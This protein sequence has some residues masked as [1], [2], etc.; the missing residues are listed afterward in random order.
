MKLTEDAKNYILCINGGSSSLKFGIYEV[1][2][3]ALVA[4][5]QIGPIG[6]N[7][8]YLEIKGASGQIIAHKPAGQKNIAAAVD[9]LI[10]WLKENEGSY[11]IRAIG[12]RVV[13][14]GPVH[15][16]PELITLQLLNNLQQYVYLAPNHLPDEISTIKKF[17]NAYPELNQVAC[18]DTAFH[19]QIPSY[20]K[21]Y[22]LPAEYLEKGL[23]KYGFHG[24]SYA[25]IMQQLK[26]QDA[27]AAQQ[28]IIIAHLGNGASMAAVDHGVSID[29]TMG[30]SPVGGLIMGSRCGDLDPGVLL[31][32]MNQ[33]QMAPAELDELL[34]KKAGL[35][36]IAGISD[37]Q[38]LL[39]IASHQPEAEAAL[40]AFCYSTR[41]FIGALAAAL[42]GLDTLVFTGG[43]GENAAPL[44]QRICDGLNFMGIE[45]DTQKNIGN[46]NIIS[47]TT[48]RVTIRV[49]KTDEELMMAQ[50]VNTTIYQHKQ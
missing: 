28:K 45:L 14:G 49:I 40:Q 39:K 4:R 33:Y 42:Q 43:I 30:I 1:H 11:P 23:F 36:A 37:V 12:H 24:L 21:N 22:P 41:K 19:S 32:L 25:Y 31:F 47:K 9:E 16:Q 34:S 17:I 13:Q 3:Y 15:R 50:L 29:T 7:H 20:A 18:F 27:V 48:S 2:S 6:E 26:E 10:T 5:G 38:E 46:N 35:K 8:S 44:R